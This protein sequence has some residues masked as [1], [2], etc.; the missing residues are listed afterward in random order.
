MVKYKKCFDCDFFENLCYEK[1]G[2]EEDVVIPICNKYQCCTI[3]EGTCKRHK[4]HGH[5]NYDPE[6]N[7][8]SSAGR[9]QTGAGY[10]SPLPQYRCDAGL[11]HPLRS[12]ALKGNDVSSSD[13]ALS[14]GSLPTHQMAKRDS[15]SR[16]SVLDDFLLLRPS[17]PTLDQWP[18]I[19]HRK[20]AA[21]K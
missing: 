18:W 7:D 2:L 12:S 9:K 13:T 6:L 17:S 11:R 19:L 8:V 14:V 20:E 5:R 21:E 1:L 15:S 4:R 10:C 3:P 16:P